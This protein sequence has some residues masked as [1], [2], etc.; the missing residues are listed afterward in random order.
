VPSST[1]PRLAMFDGR[2]STMRA[3]VDP[4]DAVAIPIE[5]R[6]RA[7]ASTYASIRQNTLP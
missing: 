4:R 3:S 7:D 5:K 2:T 1:S 6:G